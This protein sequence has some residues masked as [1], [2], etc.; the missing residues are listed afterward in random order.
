[1]KTE[2]LFRIWAEN[3]EN[4]K[5]KK[6]QVNKKEESRAKRNYLHFDER[7][8]SPSFFNTELL[9]SGKIASMCF[10]PFLKVIL[11]TPRYKRKKNKKGILRRYK[12]I[13]ER[14]VYYSAHKD[15]LV[16]S[17]YSFLLNERFYNKKL[18]H[19]GIDECV[20]AYRK[21]PV[22][23][24]SYK[25][26]CNIHFIK[27]VFNFIKNKGECA[28]FVADI[29][30]FFDNLDHDHLKKEWCG[31]LGIKNAKL[32]EDHFVIF[33][34]LTSF[35]YV[36]RDTLYKVFNIKSKKTV[37]KKQKN[38]IKP[39]RS[40]F[41]NGKSISKICSRND[42]IERIAKGGLIRGN[43]NRNKIEDSE[44]YGK[45]CGIMQGSPISAT[46]SNIY[47][48]SFDKELHGL[49]N[50][51]KGIYRRYSDDLLIVC[52]LDDF[53][54]FKKT[55]TENIKK[56]KL[57][58]N[59]DKI[60]DTFFLKNE[61]GDLRGY[62]ENSNNSKYKNLQ[63][64]GFEFNGNDIFIRSA[65]LAKYYR[66]MKFKIRKATRL[67]YGKKSKTKKEK[68]KVFKKSLFKR[69]LYKGRRSFISYAL[70]SALILKSVSIKKQLLG[71]FRIMNKSLEKS[72]SKREKTKK[73]KESN[74]KDNAQ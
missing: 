13:K 69:Y 3:E 23:E 38:K 5:L 36:E 22:A 6:R 27:E 42:F 21:I 35:K 41:V 65:S 47:M 66:T 64:L 19:F 73:H 63:Y 2:E 58:I 26:K 17:W 1:M 60:N 8:Q 37:V 14:P 53:D 32:P 20:L 51:K 29:S 16:Y 7:R 45:I 10:W 25:N 68:N 30:S 50:E 33:N 44:R 56:Y 54:F 31:V 34:N 9:D 40:F 12:D 67:A 62:E 46:L 15:A 72:I 57:T 70:N 49:A 24:K 28:V 39:Y 48:L 4:N 11:K 55:M 18:K 61:S 74:K 71:R 43:E 59:P 52:G